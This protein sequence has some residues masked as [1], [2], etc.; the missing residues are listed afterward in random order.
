MTTRKRGKTVIAFDF[1]G[2]ILNGMKFH[3]ILAADVM[4]K[5]FGM[6]KQEAMRRYHETTG[7]PFPKQLESIFPKEGPEKIKA[8]ADEY[9][10]RKV[11]EVFRKADLFPGVRDA[12]A[13]LKK[14]GYFLMVTTATE[15]KI[16]EE[17]LKK[18]GIR[19]Y[20]TLVWGEEYGNKTEHI[21]RIQKRMKPRKMIFI[22]DSPNQMFKAHAITVGMAGSPKSGMHSSKELKDAG[23]DYVIR[24][25]IELV[26]IVKK[27]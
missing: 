21:K 7:I 25:L 16:T 12:L 18:F 17:I 27:I 9:I 4:N 22:D 20:F 8:C 26:P 5:H 23:A 19:M 11:D 2:V 1:D 14:A 10:E 13:S 6:P 3:G 15:T 24:N